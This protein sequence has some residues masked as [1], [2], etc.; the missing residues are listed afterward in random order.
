MP[1]G[2]I[3]EIV[4]R[5]PHAMLGYWNDPEKTAETFRNGWFHRGDSGVIDDEG[6]LTVVDRKKDMIKTGGENV[7]S[8]EVE[9]VIY[10][11]PAVAEVAV[12]GM[13]DDRSGSRR[14]PRPSCCATGQTLDADELDRVL[15]RA[16][17]RVQGAQADHRSSTSCRRT[18]AARSS[19][20]SCGRE[21]QPS[22]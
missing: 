14:W 21:A 7:A 4:H 17:R 2:E 12:F 18:P 9:E 16:P 3:G 20:A 19:S 15:P 8:R 6:Y 1:A 11:H 13:P 5:S 22:T 10:Q